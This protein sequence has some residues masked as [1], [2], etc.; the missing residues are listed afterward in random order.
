M[1]FK[2]LKKSRKSLARAG[3]IKTEHGLIQTPAFVAV[4]TKATVKALTPEMIKSAGIEL[5][6]ANTYHLYLRPG[7]KII[8]KAGGIH[9]FSGI[10]L[11]IMT[12]SGGFQVFS[13]GKAFDSKANKFK[14]EKKTKQTN[15]SSSA[16]AKITEEGVLFK[17][18]L[19]GLDH[20][21]TPEKSIQ[22]QNDIGADIIFAFDECPSPEDKKDYQIEAMDRTHRWAIRSLNY[23]KKY[24]PKEQAI[25]GI[26]QGGRYKDLRKKSAKFI[27]GLD[28]D[29]YGIGGTFSKKDISLTIKEVNKILPEEKPRHLLGIG[30]PEDL[31]LAILAGC[32]TFDCVLPTRLGRNGSLYSKRGR[33]NILNGKFKNDFRPIEKDCECYTCKNYTRGYV[34][35]LFKSGEILASILASTHNLYFLADLV[36]TERE[37]ILKGKI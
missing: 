37:K 33:I 14:A 30:E 18:P 20:F 25:F 23:H 34:H 1:K 15:N 32:D 5:V 35:H 8:K 28:F 26:V 9:K 11:P 7:E 36:K 22:I 4:G 21:F 13:L 24:G 17:S 6:I 10:D 19:D 2:I 27:S 16:L 12:D 3:V 31:R 29:G